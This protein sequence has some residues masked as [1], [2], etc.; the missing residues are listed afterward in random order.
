MAIA[1]MKR[2]RVISMAARREELL[3]GLL[4]LG[5]V[6][7]SEPEERLS[8][9]E[10]A[11][12]LRRNGSDPAKIKGE[13]AQ[14][15][16]ALDAVSRYGETKEGLFIQRRSVPEAVFLS[17]AALEEAKAESERICALLR[18]LSR[19]ENEENRLESRRAGLLPWKELDL[20]LEESGSACTSFR[21]EVC[22]AGVNLEEVRAALEDTAAD[23]LE[24]S[25][26]KQ[27]LYTLLLSHKAE[28]EQA[29]ERL[30]PF[31]FSVTSFQGVTGTAAENIA[32][33]DRQLEE[34]RA[35][36]EA[37][38]EQLRAS[39]AALRRPPQRGTLPRG[40]RRT[41]PDR[42]DGSFL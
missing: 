34:N 6:E 32:A 5:C 13:L 41:A 38:T 20:P 10:W 21:L 39:L 30:R 42:R 29:Q 24:I 7:I 3:K 1:R 23:V 31:N 12:L 26:D 27:Q 40:E 14:A 9:P 36:Q 8:D 28:E 35:A 25:A 19:L 4:H 37:V 22:P 16:T 18:E 2:I 15:H 17:D 33:L 11:A